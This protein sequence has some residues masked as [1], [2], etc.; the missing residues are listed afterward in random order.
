MADIK[1]MGYNDLAQRMT[2]DAET[3]KAGRMPESSYQAQDSY[4][5]Q[6]KARQGI[7]LPPSDVAHLV[8]H[9]PVDYTGEDQ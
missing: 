4:A 3:A 2:T 1:S 6:A 5:I 9:R 7:A 8:T